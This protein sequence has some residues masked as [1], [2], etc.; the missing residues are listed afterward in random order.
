M[1]NRIFKNPFQLASLSLSL[2]MCLFFVSCDDD[3]MVI[4][5]E[6]MATSDAMVNIPFFVETVDFNLPSDPSDLLF[7]NRLHNPLLAPDGHQITWGEFS[8]VRGTINV[9][10][11]PEGTQVNLRVTGLIPDGVYTIWNVSVKDP[12]FDPA[13]EMF[14]IVG[15]GASGKGDGSDNTF[16]AGPDGTAEIT[17]ISQGGDLS[18]FGE[19]SDCPLS[20]QFEW[21]VVG[22]Y[23]LDG[24][25]YGPDLGPD[26]TVAEQFGF[27]F[28]NGN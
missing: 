16:V 15:I 10:C 19:L 25:T 26:G 11:S 8:A 24:R 5:E 13:A 9:E 1:K 20:E 27:I 17:T 12:G 18:M 14:N 2:L 22:T 28:Q 3:S 6:P 23:H 4:E 7:E 21:H